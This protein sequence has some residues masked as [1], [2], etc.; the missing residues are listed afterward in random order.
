MHIHN[1]Y[2]WLKDNLDTA[3]VTAFEQGVARLCQ[4]V[5]VES[6]WYGKPAQTN[7]DVVENS[8]AYGLVL[9]FQ[10]LAAHDRYQE[11]DVHL[12]F[13]AEH[14][15]KWTRVVVHDIESKG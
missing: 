4:D 7:R 2:F 11:G 1:V 9:V 3:D 10:D 12:K 8:Y 5:A 14:L 13:V 15:N 6:G